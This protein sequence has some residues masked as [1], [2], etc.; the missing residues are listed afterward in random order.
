MKKHRTS[1]ARVVAFLSALVILLM[2]LP[3]SAFADDGKLDIHEV[4]DYYEEK[5]E[6]LNYMHDITYNGSVYKWYSKWSVNLY[7][8]SDGYLVDN[9]DLNKD[10]R[11]MSCA[12]YPF[13]YYDTINLGTSG[14]HQLQN[15]I[16]N[17]KEM[18]EI[19]KDRRVLDVLEKG[20]SIFTESFG[21]VMA[22]YA[23]G[24][25][26]SVTGV[27][28]VLLKQTT[29]EIK[30]NLLDINRIYANLQMGLMD[31]Y[32][33]SLGDI[34]ETIE[35]MDE[36]DWQVTSITEAREYVKMLDSFC[37]NEKSA[38]PLF[39]AV[40]TR[41]GEL[42][43]SFIANF[44]NLLDSLLDDYLDGFVGGALDAIIKQNVD[45][46]TLTQEQIAKLI[47]DTQ[48][49]KDYMKNPSRKI[50]D[51]IRFFA[52]DSKKYLDTFNQMIAAE[53]NFVSAITQLDRIAKAE[54]QWIMNAHGLEPN[55]VSGT[56][57]SNLTWELNL[58]TGVMTIDGKGAMNQ[59]TYNNS[60]N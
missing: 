45:F 49:V 25:Q 60:S 34:M 18:I 48:K 59:Y 21:S 3:L 27:G 9:D 15:S 12:N 37:L 46:G 28:Q 19:M 6:T 17:A 5:G 55:T 36:P 2:S 39:N 20:L 1:T 50:L 47:V 54:I 41:N 23:G 4:K 52:S 38:E 33:Y 53:D 58:A 26:L 13:E 56:C 42:T 29:S 16:K 43:D 35:K 51:T 10:L 57:G 32:T 8:D 22:V 14:D 30:K 7:F 40:V 31:F 11:D 24:G 44:A